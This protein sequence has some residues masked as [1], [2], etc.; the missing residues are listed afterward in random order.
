MVW[1]GLRAGDV[2][3]TRTGSPDWRQQIRP[4]PQDLGH[5][6]PVGISN[7]T[8]S[9]AARMSSFPAD[10]AGQLPRTSVVKEI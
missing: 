10:L 8:L 2:Q 4:G 6:N 3:P 1:A 9:D 7:L 5:N